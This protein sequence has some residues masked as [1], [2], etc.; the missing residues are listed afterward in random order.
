MKVETPTAQDVHVIRE[1]WKVVKGKLL[2]RRSSES[3][4]PSMTFAVTMYHN[5]FFIAPEMKDLFTNMNKQIKALGGVLEMMVNRLDDIQAVKEDTY[6]LGIRHISYGVRPDMFEPFGR[7][8][9]KTLRDY[10]Q[11]EFTPVVERTWLKSYNFI[12]NSMIAGIQA[13]R[14]D[15]KQNEKGCIIA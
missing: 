6:Q 1:S 7:A 9:I 5:L 10:G 13:G 4:T 14:G 15:N 11:E 2:Q 3:E 12:V 8:L